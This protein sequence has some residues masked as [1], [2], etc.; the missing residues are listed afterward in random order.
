M[1]AWDTLQRAKWFLLAAIVTSLFGMSAVAV[2]P[3]VINL[4]TPDIW[5]YVFS[6]TGVMV[7][8]GVFALLCECRPG[9][10]L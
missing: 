6:V 2:Y 10:T 9:S 5:F 4:L 3:T 8:W 7:A 1:L